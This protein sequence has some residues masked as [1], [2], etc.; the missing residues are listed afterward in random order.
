MGTFTGVWAQARTCAWAHSQG[1]GLRLGLARGHMRKGVGSG[2]EVCVGTFTGVWAQAR[3][4]AWAHSQ[5]CGFRLGLARGHI[6]RGV[7]S[8]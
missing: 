7:G 4:C 8:G 3:T 5:G 1:C 2:A 6:H